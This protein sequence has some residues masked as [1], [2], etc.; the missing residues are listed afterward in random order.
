M[1]EPVKVSKSVVVDLI[2]ELFDKPA[3]KDVEAPRPR[4][5][6]V[7]PI[8][9]NPVVDPMAA[10]SDPDNKKFLPQNKAEFQ[11]A[12]GHIDLP[13]EKFDD[14]YK[15]INQTIK[16]LRKESETSSISTKT[17]KKDKENKKMANQRRDTQA[18]AFVRMQVRKILKEN[19]I[20]SVPIGKSLPRGTNVTTGD[21]T[22]Q[23][24]QSVL[25]VKS[26]QSVID[27]M[28]KLDN[29][30]HRMSTFANAF[31]SKYN[32]I[33]LANE[34]EARD[35]I[36]DE[37]VKN[38]I[39][40]ETI[41]FEKK[42][43]MNQAFLRKKIESDWMNYLNNK[44]RIAGYS[45]GKNIFSGISEYLNGLSE[46]ELGL[47]SDD[48]TDYFILFSQLMEE[49]IEGEIQNLKS[50]DFD[51]LTNDMKSAVATVLAANPGD[52]GLA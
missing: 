25:G 51:V 40:K 39:S 14:L 29:K 20:G 3:E 15:K 46:D 2:R 31:P 23:N 27:F 38:H 24:L 13:E 35:A 10:V 12:M 37:V 30:I 44:D 50:G 52:L 43:K 21:T 22:L 33:H 7:Q 5:M 42:Y 49:S 6:K 36:N 17:M 11:V 26:L 4:G 9:A 45:S 8:S 34:L 41:S 28:A 18:E 1:M 19:G 32:E 16:D 47:I 48:I